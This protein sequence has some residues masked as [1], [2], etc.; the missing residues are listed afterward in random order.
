MQSYFLGLF[1]LISLLGYGQAKDFEEMVG[2]NTLPK[3]DSLKIRI[4]DN[5]VDKKNLGIVQVGVNNRRAPVLNHAPLEDILRNLIGATLQNELTD[6][7][8]LVNLRVLN[9]AETTKALKELGF[10]R[11]RAELY[12]VNGNYYSELSTIDTLVTVQAMDVTNKMIK[13]GITAFEEWI[14]NGIRR[15]PDTTRKFT[16]NMVTQ[17][18]KLEKKEMALYLGKPLVNGIYK[19]YKELVNVEPSITNAEIIPNESSEQIRAML[20][21][22][23]QPKKL[24]NK[25]GY[26]LVKNDKL[27]ILTPEGIS[28]AFP[29]NGF[30]HFKAL[31]N[32]DAAYDVGGATS[33]MMFGLVGGLIYYSAASPQAMRPITYRVDHLTGAWLPVADR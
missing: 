12:L 17:R 15:L 1:T 6:K 25:D 2:Y 30:I 14:K 22:N 9:F 27:Y 24:T 18:D 10:F 21:G 32:R 4:L 3:A 29:H 11:L 31:Y 28:E 5:R 23:K 16:L 26:A 33:M 7:S 8:I 13:E 19:N 20:P